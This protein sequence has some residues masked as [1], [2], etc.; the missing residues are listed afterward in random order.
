MPFIFWV[1]IAIMVHGYDAHFN[2]ELPAAGI[3]HWT[4]SP[5]YSL[6]QIMTGGG[7]DDSAKLASTLH[8]GK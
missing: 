4:C 2:F 8:A 6:T 1:V 7:G 3:C 5:V